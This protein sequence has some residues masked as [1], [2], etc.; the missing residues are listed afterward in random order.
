MIDYNNYLTIREHIT[1]EQTSKIHEE[2]LETADFTTEGV[3]E[4]WKDLIESATKYIATLTEWSYLTKEQKMSK[5]S[6]RMME[7]NT[8]INNFI[9]LERVFKM[10]SWKSDT[11]TDQLFLQ[12]DIQKRTRQDETEHKQRIGDFAYYLTFI[13]A[14]NGR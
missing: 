3:S 11:W 2:I 6:S 10:N 13:Y 8:L 9:V 14:I 1:F 5:D 12:E 7:H 4:I